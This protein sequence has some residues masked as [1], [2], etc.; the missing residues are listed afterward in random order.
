[1]PFVYA[2]PSFEFI[3]LEPGCIHPYGRLPSLLGFFDKLVHEV[4]E[5]KCQGNK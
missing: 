2:M 3:G 1:M 4:T 5:E